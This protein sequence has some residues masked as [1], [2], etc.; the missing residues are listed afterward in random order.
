MLAGASTGRDIRRNAASLAERNQ[1]VYVVR[2]H[3]ETGH[4]FLTF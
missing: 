4:G 2:M 3:L 1:S